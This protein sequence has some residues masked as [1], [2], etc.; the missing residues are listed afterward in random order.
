MFSLRTQ[1]AVIAALSSKSWDVETATE[2]L[3]S[4]WS[5]VR[6]EDLKLPSSYHQLLPGIILPLPFVTQT[7]PQ[8]P[9][10][11][12][13]FLTSLYATNSTP[14]APQWPICTP[15]C[16]LSDPIIMLSL[17]MCKALNTL[18]HASC[19]PC[20]LIILAVNLFFL[21]S[22]CSLILQRIK[23]LPFPGRFSRVKC[24]R[25]PLY[26]SYSTSSFTPSADGPHIRLFSLIDI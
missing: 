17:K 9:Q 10:Q 26:C 1:N 7:T 24:K 22:L 6:C 8:S 21:T 18:N 3:L 5:P 4:N 19:L 11:S 12:E 20:L 16:C 15:S 23:W 25:N 14:V 2:L 13:P